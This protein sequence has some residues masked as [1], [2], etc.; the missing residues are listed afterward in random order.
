MSKKLRELQ[1]KKASAAQAKAEHLKTAGALLETAATEN[2]ELSDTEQATFDG[3]K[4]SADTKGSEL[5]RIQAQIDNE[6]DLIA[7]TA[8]AQGFVVL[9]GNG[10]DITVTENSAADPKAGF[11]A[12]GEF[13][14]SVFGA[15]QSRSTGRA[16]DSRLFNAAAPTTYGN[17][18]NG[19]DGGFLVPPQFSRDIFTL[20]LG[21]SSLLPYVDN[22]IVEGNSMG[23]PRDETTPHG[24]NGIRAYWQGEATAATATKPVVGLDTL[25][26]KKLM[27]LVPVS[28]E[29]L[30]DVSAMASYLPKKIGAS[31]QWKTNEA[32]L[33]GP[34]GNQ[35]AG[36]LNSGAA[37]TIT[38]DTNQATNTLTALNLANMI[39]RLPEG[40]FPN[41]VWIINNDVLPA[42]FT[43]TLGNYPIY[44]PAGS[45]G[46]LQ[47][48]PYGT[49]LGRPIIVS[50]HA[51]GFSA[52]GDVSLVDLS[53]Y[54]AITHAS[55]MESAT[56]MHLYFDAGATAFRTV[57]RFDGQ[58]KISTAIDPANGTNKLSPFV[59]LG[60]R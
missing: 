23:F 48:S 27:A 49:L 36:A 29:L 17:E 57:Y 12:F 38:K 55:G 10:S 39:A 47:G 26:L 35:P 14:Q 54:Q 46:S 4:A 25:R 24:S 40:S 34:G 45:V 21:D 20:S 56:S 59:L 9:S 41:S 32:I 16:I 37:V 42:L 18:S 33:F 52:A 30:S 58:S 19:A 15:A 6:Q 5:A 44:L 50:Q 31:I 13:A 2:R 22:V 51:K 11:K 1:S 53:Y 8:S 43:M 3:L 28:D 7:A 60:A